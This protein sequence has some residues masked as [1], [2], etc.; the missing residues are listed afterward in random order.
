MFMIRHGLGRAGAGAAGIINGGLSGAALQSTK[1][2]GRNV[3][4]GC[5]NSNV[6]K[7]SYN[8][9]IENGYTTS[10]ASVTELWLL[11]C[12][13]LPIRFHIL[14]DYEVKVLRENIKTAM[15][16]EQVCFKK[17]FASVARSSKAASEKRLGLL[18][19]LCK[20]SF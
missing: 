16:T 9:A 20:S 19:S 13:K 14:G 15:K 18:W 10:E 17:L 11:L 8:E 6:C 12:G 2:S 1:Q 4:K 3:S 7:D 5:I